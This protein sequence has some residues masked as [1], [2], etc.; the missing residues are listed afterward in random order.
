MPPLLHT[1]LP[2]R[3]KFG[4]TQAEASILTDM[5]DLH[6]LRYSIT[7]AVTEQYSWVFSTPG[8][9]PGFLRWESVLYR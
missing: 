1:P 3:T 7:N 8:V 2:I 9:E 4:S 5:Q 6:L